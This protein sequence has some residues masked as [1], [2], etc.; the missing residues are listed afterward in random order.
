MQCQY[1]YLLYPRH[2]LATLTILS[3]SRDR[4]MVISQSYLTLTYISN[5][6]LAH[7]VWIIWH[8][9]AALPKKVLIDMLV[10]HQALQSPFY[11][12]LL[13]V[14]ANFVSGGF[15]KTICVHGCFSMYQ[16]LVQCGVCLGFFCKLYNLLQCKTLGNAHLQKGCTV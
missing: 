1:H 3:R 4:E 16:A 11:L 6:A 13:K 14:I 5:T 8:S 12:S 7:L 15:D 9:T 10:Q 2:T